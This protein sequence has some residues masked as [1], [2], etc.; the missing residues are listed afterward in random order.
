MLVEETGLQ[1]II[2]RCRLKGKAKDGRS[3]GEIPLGP[4]RN[5]EVNFSLGLGIASNK[6]CEL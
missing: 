5:L 1:L 3:K 6:Q 4:D 2:L